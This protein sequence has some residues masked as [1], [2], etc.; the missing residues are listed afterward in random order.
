MFYN[1]SIVKFPITM[2]PETIKGEK[3]YMKEQFSLSM[4]YT[5]NK[6]YNSQQQN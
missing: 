3:S 4:S 1:A 6:I 5:N 2:K